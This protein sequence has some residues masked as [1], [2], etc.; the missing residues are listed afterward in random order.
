M[1]EKGYKLPMYAR[2]DTDVNH[3]APQW[4]CYS[5]SS[6]SPGAP[7]HSVPAASLPTCA[8]E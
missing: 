3:D 4:R 2:N 6:L 7:G 5:P 8:S 1:K